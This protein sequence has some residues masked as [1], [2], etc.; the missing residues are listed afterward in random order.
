VTASAIYT[1]MVHH[2]RRVGR[3]HAFRYPIALQYVDLA[4]VDSLLDGRLV[5][6]GFG[7]LRFRR[8]DYFGDR[9]VPL[10]DAVRAHVRNETGI[11][12]D[13][14]VRL[15]TQLRS[16]GHCFNPVSFYYCF[17]TAEQVLAIVAEVTNTPWGERHA[18]VLAPNAVGELTGSFPKRLHVSPF[19]GMNQTYSW[20]ATT[21][22]DSIVVHLDNIEDGVRV[23]EAT[24]ALRRHAFDAAT[25]RRITR[26]YPAA[27]LRSLALIYGHAAALRTK[28]VRFVKHPGASTREPTRTR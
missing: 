2:R 6:K 17:D 10:G 4:E 13:G 25:V 24:L 1:G 22:S 14:A 8:Q 9:S 23:F 12:V 11:E 26:R 16:F 15:L 27:S 20:N 19:F 18:Y 3:V 5:R 21:P 7:V 28:G